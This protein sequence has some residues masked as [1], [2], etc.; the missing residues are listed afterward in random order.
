MTRR[1][2]SDDPSEG[3]RK[4][5]HPNSQD[6]HST[7]FLLEKIY[8]T[9]FIFGENSYFY[10]VIKNNTTMLNTTPG[11]SI[12][13]SSVEDLKNRLKSGPVKFAFRKKDGSLRLAYGT[14]DLNKI[15]SDQQPKGGEAS[16]K[17]LPF[18]DLEKFAWRSVQIG[19]L[20]FS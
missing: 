11:P 19:Q 15:P 4:P 9:F 7:K 20:I 14:L 16:P 1:P 17:I 3:A 12:P 18:Y 5:Q 13:Q 2:N 6:E 8:F 10:L